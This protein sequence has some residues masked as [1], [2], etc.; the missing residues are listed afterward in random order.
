MDLGIDAIAVGRG[1]KQQLFNLYDQASS[2][3]RCGKLDNID[4]AQHAKVIVDLSIYSP[5]YILLH[6]CIEAKTS[7]RRTMDRR[8]HSCS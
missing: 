8:E 7:V 1:R 6:A 4:Y 2:L 5:R 3:P